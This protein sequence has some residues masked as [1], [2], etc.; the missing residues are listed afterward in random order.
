MTSSVRVVLNAWEV[1]PPAALAS[2]LR[3]K[4]CPDS[5]KREREGGFKTSTRFGYM[6]SKGQNGSVL[7]NVEP[8]KLP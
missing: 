2:G 7:L 6:G 3:R 5:T 1:G 8:R 4:P